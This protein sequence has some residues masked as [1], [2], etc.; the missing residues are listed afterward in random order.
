MAPNIVVIVTDDQPR[1]LMDAMPFARNYL[2]TNG[3]NFL[4]AYAPAAL[5]AVS[6]S[7]LLTGLPAHDH[8][9]WGNTPPYGWMAL[10]ESDTIAVKL[11]ALG[12]RTGLVGK[13]MNGWNAHAT[14]VPAGWSKFHTIDPDDGGDGAYYNYSIRGTDPT[15]HYG[16]AETD[17]STDVLTGL[18]VNFINTTNASKPLFLYYSPFG[19]HSGYI[20]APR[21]VGSWTDPV[22]L[23]PCVNSDNYGMAPWLQGLD[24]LDEQ[25]LIDKTV[26][27]HETVMSI[28]EGIEQIVNALVAKGRTDT[29][30]VFLGDNGLQLGEH[31]LN[32]KY[33]PYQA[34]VHLQMMARWDGHFTPDTFNPP[35]TVMDMHQLAVDAADGSAALP[36]NNGGVLL[37]GAATDARPAYIGWRTRNFLYV[38]YADGFEELFDYDVDPH[39][40]VNVINNPEHANRVQTFS[41]N[42]ESLAIPRPPGWD[43]YGNRYDDTYGT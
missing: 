28:D 9:V 34:S 37:E 10:D 19:A 29:L 16:D 42:A 32:G 26:A 43:T 17:Y 30:F 41:T 22:V 23:N 13:Y 27:Q 31:R 20:P 3:V 11:K 21:H 24:P 33:V 36:P 7:S 25:E 2:R 39:E 38:Q 40:L 4:N 15:V 18:A 12:Y 1:G 8:G 5:C 6:R 35:V 14:A